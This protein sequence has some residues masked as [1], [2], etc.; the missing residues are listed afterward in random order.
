MGPVTQA[1]WQIL[2]F[3][4]RVIGHYEVHRERTV[5]VEDHQQPLVPYQPVGRVG[6]WG[7]RAG[8]SGEA[9]Q[10]VLVG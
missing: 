8:L 5:G 9:Q 2:G 1:A 6:K 10:H 7:W 4:G 3:I